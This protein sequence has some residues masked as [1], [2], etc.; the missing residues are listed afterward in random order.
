MN[1][2]ETHL[3]NNS[4]LGNAANGTYLT[5]HNA[6]LGVRVA[7]GFVMLTAVLT[8]IWADPVSEVWG[9]ALKVFSTAWVLF[10]LVLW[11]KYR[12]EES[13]AGGT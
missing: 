9:V 10:C 4:D 3:A 12:L 7:L 11:G 5:V 6:L 1:N 13:T 2:I 8:L